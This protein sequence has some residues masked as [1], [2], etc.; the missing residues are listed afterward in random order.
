MLNILIK[1][2]DYYK[3]VFDIGARNFRND[4]VYMAVHYMNGLTDSDWAKPMPGNM[5]YTLDRDRLNE[6][7]DDVL[8]FLLAKENKNGESYLLRQKDKMYM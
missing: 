2:W 5:Y 3:T 1:N 7:K 6:I 4:L 8:Q